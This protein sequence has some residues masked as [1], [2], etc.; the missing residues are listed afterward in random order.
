LAAAIL[1]QWA[2]LKRAIDRATTVDDLSP[3][4]AAQVV[5]ESRRY[6]ALR[7]LA[8]VARSEW[9]SL[10]EVWKSSP[11]SQG[12]GQTLEDFFAARQVAR[13][14]GSTEVDPA[15][16]EAGLRRTAALAG[17]GRP[18][19]G[20]GPNRPNRREDSKKAQALGSAVAKLIKSPTMRPSNA[21][22]IL[23]DADLSVGK[24]EFLLAMRYNNILLGP[25]GILVDYATNTGM[26]FGKM[27]A[28]PFLLAAS[29]GVV[30][31]RAWGAINAA[32]YAAL[33]RAWPLAKARAWRVITEGVSDLESEVTGTPR[34]MSGRFGRRIEMAQMEG[35]GDYS[36][37]VLMLKT[38][39]IAAVT[40]GE[41]AGRLKSVADVMIKELAFGMEMT[42]QAAVMAYREGDHKTGSEEWHKRVAEILAGKI[43]PNAKT[44]EEKVA[45]QRIHEQMLANSY[46]EAERTTFQGPMGQ[47]GRM[48]EPIHRHPVGQFVL[49]FLRALYHIS[50]WAIDLSPIGAMATVGDVIRSGIYRG[51]MRDTRPEDQQRTSMTAGQK[52]LAKTGNLGGFDKGWIRSGGLLGGPYQQAWKGAEVGPGVADLDRRILA[53]VIGTSAWFYILS[54]AFAGAISGVGPPDEA[55]PLIDP[56]RPDFTQTQLRATMEAKGWRRYSVRINWFNGKTYWVNYQNWGPLGYMLG[57]AAAV[58]ETYKYGLSNEKKTATTT[59]GKLYELATQGDADMFRSGS[60]RFFG[61]MK[62]MSY[63]QGL[64]DLAEAVEIGL[65][66]G[67]PPP[68]ESPSDRDKRQKQGAAGL[69]AWAAWQFIGSFLPNSQLV[70]T[71][72]QSQDAWTRGSEFGSIPQSLAGRIPDTLGP[73]GLTTNAIPSLLDDTLGS[74]TGRRAGLPVKVDALGRPIPNEYQGIWAWLPFRAVQEEIGNK[75]LDTLIAAGVG[76]P[77]PPSEMYYRPIGDKTSPV[78]VQLPTHLRQQIA[79]EVGK[80]ADA[81]V[82]KLVAETPVAQQQGTAWSDKLKEAMKDVYFSKTREISERPETKLQLGRIVQSDSRRVRDYESKNQKDAIRGAGTN[83]EKEQGV[84]P[85][86]TPIPGPTP[87]PGSTPTATPRQG[88]TPAATPRPGVTPTPAAPGLSPAQLEE[89][90]RKARDRAGVGR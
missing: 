74:T 56:E 58:A 53:N 7:G 84:T 77:T 34:H 10:A 48:M 40:F 69:S 32:E 35:A 85:S 18:R 79:A 68:G 19:Y 88:A 24:T 80:E 50:H 62:D 13:D 59:M 66:F 21:G 87:R 23:S 28:D 5:E 36:K 4:A 29:E 12:E 82:Q 20:I 15:T 39:R 72:G 45:A 51:M 89:E 57:S 31:P 42:R 81:R 60:R 14:D 6:T 27:M 61:T 70:N 86:G 22:S 47:L 8:A 78:M 26:L 37:R 75:S 71:I 43:N 55:V 67:P 73:P 1:L 83:E 65:K 63:W 52:F 49:P 46:R 2:R 30:N 76:A 64:V 38:G 16:R 41:A 90:R 44:R 9:P 25:R 3:W 33:S 11:I 17:Q 54:L